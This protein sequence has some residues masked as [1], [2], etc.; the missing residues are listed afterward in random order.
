MNAPCC[1]RDTERSLSWSESIYNNLGAGDC[2][3][4]KSPRGRKGGWGT[5]VVVI[6]LP[7]AVLYPPYGYT[8]AGL[9]LLIWEPR[10]GFPSYLPWCLHALWS[11]ESS[12]AKFSFPP[13][14]VS[15]GLWLSP[16]CWNET[17]GFPLQA[18]GAFSSSR[19]QPAQLW[20]LALWSPLAPGLSGVS[21]KSPRPT[22]R[23]WS[24][25]TDSLFVEMVALGTVCDRVTAPDGDVGI[26]GES[27]VYYYYY[28]HFF[29]LNSGSI[30]TC[31]TVAQVMVILQWWVNFQEG[32]CH[33]KCW[34]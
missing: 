16:R 8:S 5:G 4:G 26:P 7:G 1:W 25:R 30:S 29:H 2:S 21:S 17:G 19:E 3:S 23:G 13:L 9:T 11:H 10:S 32:K 33:P 24:W 12:S 18:S 28:Y 22:E 15:Q 27:C 31:D 34:S 14:S 20:D 6:D